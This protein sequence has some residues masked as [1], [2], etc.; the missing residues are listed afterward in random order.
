MTPAPHILWCRP[1]R[2]SESNLALDDKI[3]ADRSVVL[4]VGLK[5]AVDGGYQVNDIVFHHPNAGTQ[6]EIDG[7]IYKAVPHEQVL[8]VQ[9]RETI[10]DVIQKAQA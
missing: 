1:A 9:R 6:F 8:A 4:A 5:A 7:T 2:I 10:G 3:W